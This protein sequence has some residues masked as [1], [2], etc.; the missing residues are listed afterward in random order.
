MHLIKRMFSLFSSVSIGS[1]TRLFILTESGATQIGIFL[2][3]FWTHELCLVICSRL[4]LPLWPLGKQKQ[5]ELFHSPASD[6]ASERAPRCG[7]QCSLMAGAVGLPAGHQWQ[8]SPGSL[9][10]R[11]S[12]GQTWVSRP[13]PPN[14]CPA[15]PSQGNAVNQFA[16]TEEPQPPKRNH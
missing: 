9:H 4:Q 7:S 16:K 2:L 1:E 15:S 13:R 11:S 10:R 3:D 14:W 5:L 8:R 12:K 6:S